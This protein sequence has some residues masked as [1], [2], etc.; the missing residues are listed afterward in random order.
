MPLKIEYIN[1]SE[2]KVYERN[3]RT[4]SPEQIA[5]LVNSINEF[6]FTNPVLI[7]D[8]GELIAG[9]GRTE[10]AKVC[11]LQQVPAIRLSGLTE[12]QIKALRISDNQLALNAGWDLDL[13]A[14]ELTDLQDDDFNLELLGFD[15]DFIDGL[16]DESDAGDDGYEEV[17]DDNDDDQDKADVTVV[18]G[19]YRFIVERD[20]WDKWENKL[21]DTAGFH[22]NDCIEKIQELLGL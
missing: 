14:A 1:L 18:V 6:G 9:H 13:L 7:D 5:Q 12:N 21:R 4:H 3:A 8:N 11:G 20:V 10:A 2:L 16:L 15:D 22:K 17:P 19:P